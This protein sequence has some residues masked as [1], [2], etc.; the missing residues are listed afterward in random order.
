[1]RE[2][3]KEL[4]YRKYEANF[5]RELLRGNKQNARLIIRA[6][7]KESANQSYNKKRGTISN[8]QRKTI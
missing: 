5:N 8:V 7:R 2:E 1:M 3:E 6:W 4:F